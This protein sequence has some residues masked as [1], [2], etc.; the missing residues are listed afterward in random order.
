MG[1]AVTQTKGSDLLIRQRAKR[2]LGNLKGALAALEG[3]GLMQ[4]QWAIDDPD[5]MSE[6]QRKALR[7]E[8]P[9]PSIPV[10]PV[11]EGG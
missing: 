11:V 9:K 1:V 2:I 6:D 10:V 8:K 3:A 7:K 4:P 5:F